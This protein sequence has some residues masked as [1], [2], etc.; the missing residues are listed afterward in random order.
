MNNFEV[1]VDHNY[2]RILRF[3]FNPWH[4]YA[5][6]KAEAERADVIV[7]ENQQRL[8]RMLEETEQATKMLMEIE[9]KREEEAKEA[10]EKQREQ[11]KI[12]K[13]E[14]SR[15][16]LRAERAAESRILM[17]IQREARR[18]RVEADIEHIKAVF[19]ADYEEKARDMY[20]RAK[21]RITSYIDNPENKL[22]LELKMQQLKREFHANPTP[23]TK[24]KER[25]LSS[26][27]NILFL[28][29]DA[30]LTLENRHIM[31][32][33]PDF[34]R[35]QK[36][37]LTYGEFG[38]L[39][40]SVGAQ[41][42][43]SQVSSV[44]R[45]VDTDKDGYVDFKEIEQSFQEINQMGV[46]GSPW[47]MYV[48][49]AE[50]VIVYHNFL[51]GEK[52][53]EYQ[54]ND[55]IFKTIVIANLYGDAEYRTKLQLMEIR[56]EM[57]DERLKN[58]MIK[59]LHYMYRYWKAKNWR[60][61]KIWKVEKKVL[62]YRSQQQ[63]IIIKFIE[64]VLYSFQCRQNFKKQLHLTIEKVYDIDSVR[65][66]Y[67]NHHTKESSWEM[68]R[69]LRRY[70]DVTMPC[71]WM[72]MDPVDPEDAEDEE[73]GGDGSSPGDKKKHKKKKN[74]KKSKKTIV[75]DGPTR[76]W[77]IIAKREFPKKPDGFPLCSVCEHFLAIRTCK[78]CTEQYCFSC[79]RK[80]HGH[81]L[82]FFQNVKVKKKQYTNPR[83]SISFFLC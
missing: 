79:H 18:K 53:F 82:G 42:N 70:G 36:G 47:K 22:A 54:M 30:K 20:L 6:E 81:P 19:H 83:K 65:L 21:D 71:I 39:I 68:P 80:T 76:Y 78:Q 37:Y 44:I 34:D 26:Y 58:Y 15:Q 55:K 69:L 25:I 8:E 33:L 17:A 9:R 50:D 4:H 61:K 63:K 10:A 13:L 59:R 64:K 45:G 23:E 24:E 48:D 31:E 72:P 16:V 46:P 43:E 35:G 56:K 38:N 75:H 29:L 11:E 28:Y 40:R 51:T 49:P 66:F 41:L 60:R 52:Y 77:H 27:R 14:Q 5:H 32:L 1:A 57:W 73:G 12:E 2:R 67:Y 7:R 3:V 62:K 74:K